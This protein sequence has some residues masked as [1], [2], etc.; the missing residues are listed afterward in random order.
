MSLKYIS[1]KELKS[2]KRSELMEVLMRC[3]HVKLPDVKR[4]ASDATLRK[5]IYHSQYNQPWYLIFVLQNIEV[6]CA[7]NE[8]FSNDMIDIYK[9]ID[10][11]LV[12]CKDIY[13]ENNNDNIQQNEHFMA[14]MIDISASSD[15]QSE[16][17]L[18]SFKHDVDH[19][20]VCNISVDNESH[21]SEN[22]LVF[23]GDDNDINPNHLDVYDNPTTQRC[24][25]NIQ[26]AECSSLIILITYA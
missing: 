24:K 1:W 22:V 21:N 15:E 4:D 6:K 7:T 11:N 26:T 23:D 19:T 25:M 12:T 10:E 20:H 9:I 3:W 2:M 8:H 16:E 13:V 5:L 18:V 14:D 17:I